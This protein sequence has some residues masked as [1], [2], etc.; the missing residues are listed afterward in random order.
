M[1]HLFRREEIDLTKISEVALT[2]LFDRYKLLPTEKVYHGKWSYDIGVVLQGVK[3]AYLQTKDTKYFNYIKETLD[4][5]IQEDGTIKNY[6][7]D[8]MN[9][10]HINNGKSLFLLYK[11][12]GEEKYKIALDKLYAQLQDMPRTSEGGFWHKKIYPHQMWLDG[13]YMG[14]P[15][16]AEYLLTFA[17]G[18]GLEEVVKQFRLCYQH[19]LDEKSGLLYHAWDEKKEQ[20]WA[21]PET[22]CSPN[23]WGRSMGWFM[24]ALADTMA[25]LASSELVEELQEMFLHCLDALAKVRDAERK[26]WYQVLDQGGKHGNYLEASA[27]SMICYATAKARDLGVIDNSWDAFIEE[28]YQGI[29][30]EFVFLTENGWLNL[31]RNCEV[32]GLGGPDKRDGSFVYYIS[33]PIITNDFKGYGAFLQASLLLEPLSTKGE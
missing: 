13:L 4:F 25:L 14:A 32:A 28:T 27:S 8:A 7:F 17:D 5:Y 3:E 18:H 33:E 29:I 21:D 26:V 2:T 1:N 9:I 30:D 23:F 12:T 20:F 24:M 6:H 19:T 10:D 22:G 15:F 31:T 11:E 16:L